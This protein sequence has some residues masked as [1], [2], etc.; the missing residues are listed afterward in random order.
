MCSRAPRRS[1]RKRSNSLQKQVCCNS[2]PDYSL[3][4][5]Y[6]LG[7]MC[8]PWGRSLRREFVASAGMRISAGLVSMVLFVKPRETCVRWSLRP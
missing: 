8:N 6:G 4:N 3:G 1:Y 5:D 2:Q 7:C